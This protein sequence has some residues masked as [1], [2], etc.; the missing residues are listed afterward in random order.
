MLTV[1]REATLQDAP[2]IVRVLRGS[3]LRFMPYAP[4]V[5]SESEDLH[6]VR[7]S[8][9]PTGGVTV[10]CSDGQVVGMLAVHHAEDAGWIDQLYVDP[11]HCG[12]GIGTQLL[13]FALS[14]LRRPVRLYTFQEN[15]CARAFYE[16]HGFGP[17]AFGDGSRN[18]EQCPD[19][20]Y[21]LGERRDAV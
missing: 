3:R 7:H 11:R 21:E 10:A 13:A 16:A 20:L 14:S 19:V 4:P 2:D 1:L 15:A 6:W 8:L 9:I 5:H 17:I 18:E 12:R